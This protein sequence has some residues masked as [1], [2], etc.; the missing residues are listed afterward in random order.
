MRNLLEYRSEPSHVSDLMPWAALVAPGV[1]LN[2]QGTFQTTIAYRGPDLDSATQ[3]E[4]VAT[5]GSINNLLRRYGDGWYFYADMHRIASTAYP[6]S[7]FPDPITYL[8][9]EERKTTFEAGRHYE[10]RYYFTLGWLPPTAAQASAR[11][12]FFTKDEGSTK[13]RRDRETVNEWLATFQVERERLITQLQNLLPEVRPLS[14]E[15]MLAYLHSTASTKRHPIT[16]TDTPIELDCLLTDVPLIGGREPMLG[17]QYIGALTIR[18]FPYRSTPGKLDR[19]NRLGYAYRWVTRWIALD[20][21]EADKEIGKVRKNWFSGRK[22]LV[23]MVKEIVTGTQSALENTDA[24]NKADDADQAQQELAADAVSYGYFSQTVLI[25]DRDPRRLE[26]K[27]QLFEREINGLGFTTV[28]ETRDGNAMEAWLGAVPGNCLHNIRRPMVHTLNLAHLMPMS[29]VWAGPTRCPNDQFPPNSPAHLYAVTGGATPFRFS[30]F[31]DDVGHTIIIGPTGAGKSVFL[32]VLEAQFR[33]YPNAQIYV[34]DKG[35]SSRILTEAVGGTFY[36]LGAVGTD[37]KTPRYA[38]QPL[39][40][41]DDERERA[42]A[43]GWVIDIL[44]AELGAENVTPENK[45]AIWSALG[46]LAAAPV[47]QRTITGLSIQVQDK[48]LK[49]ALKQYTN[50][51]A[52]GKLIDAN[53][54][55]VDLGSW[56]TFEMEELMETK[57]AVLPVLSYLFHRLDERFDGTPSLLVLDEAWLFLDHPV[58]SE[59]IREWLKVLR[60]ANVSVV[61][62][63]QDLA[64]V[65]QSRILPTVQQACM[66]KIFLPNQSALNED[67]ADFY[68]RF[69]LNKTQLQL[70]ATGVRRQDYYLTSPAGNRMFSLG[71]GPLALAYC[72]ATNKEM[73]KLASGLRDQFPQDTLAF[74]QA[75][76]AARA[77]LPRDAG[78][79]DV[80]WAVDYLRSLGHPAGA[81][82]TA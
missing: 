61:F 6:A 9:D 35:G 27:L 16:I 57:G 73:Q 31:V 59:K 23:T 7:Q 63:T 19:L 53:Y 49:T 42:W 70:I 50:Q 48:R 62:A 60:K 28:N 80:D 20:K 64:D 13:A 11:A 18:Q 4:L 51:G 43:H 26:Q 71:L 77:A 47:E 74:N 41:I 46:T 67:T 54:D 32:N 45:D 17:D 29:A 65:A 38:F 36:D 39:R 75:Y 78:G 5:S 69:S 34:F 2:K 37:G 15:D 76:L 52:F 3:E 72:A 14:D 44:I 58:F 1:V 25:Y 79:L 12:W 40:R 30:T 56:L 82:A 10:S 8:V 22:G 55:D 66:T 81:S 33:R 24:L 68:R 21:L